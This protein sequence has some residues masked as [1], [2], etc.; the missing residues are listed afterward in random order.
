MT[1]LKQEI[2]EQELSDTL[3]NVLIDYAIASVLDMQTQ[4]PEEAADNILQIKDTEVSL[5]KLDD[6]EKLTRK[7]YVSGQQRDVWIINESGLYNLIFR[8]NKPEAKAFRKWVTSEVLPQIRATGQ[9]KGEVNGV[10]DAR[11]IVYS[12]FMYNGCAIKEL[13]FDGENWYCMADFLRAIGSATTGK[14]LA[15]QLNKGQ[16]IARK[17]TVFGT[18]NPALFC[19]AHA[20]NLMA[21]GS[22]KF[23]HNTSIGLPFPQKKEVTN[24]HN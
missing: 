20:L 1:N 16:V 12:F 3:D 21:I 15:N 19:T 18:P 17:F 10:T 4:S 9:Y 13:L 5:R 7:L 11:H 23:V 8:S 14:Q 6:D 22:R 24:G 2:P